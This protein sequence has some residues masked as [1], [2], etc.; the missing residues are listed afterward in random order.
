LSLWI[1][2]VRLSASKSS[3][4]HPFCLFFYS[5]PCMFMTACC[6]CPPAFVESVCMILPISSCV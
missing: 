2:Q 3:F 4:Q 6:L 1:Q 5:F